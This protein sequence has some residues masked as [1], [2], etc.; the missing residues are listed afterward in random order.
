M[1]VDHDGALDRNAL[2]LGVDQEQRQAVA[3]ADGACGARG[4]DEEIGDVAVD[5]ERLG[6]REL[7]TVAGAHGLQVGLQRAMLCA[8]VDRK[9]REQRAVGNFWQVLGFLRG[10]AATVQRRGRDHAGGEERRRHQ[11]AAD[12]LHHDAGLHETKPAAAE[13][14]RH[15]EAG[16]THFGEG[17]PKLLGEAGGVFAIAQR[18]Q[19]R[20][21][22]LVADQAA[23]TV[24]Q[25]G[26][27]FGEDEGHGQVPLLA[28]ILNEQLNSSFRDGPKGQARN[29]YSRWWLWIPGSRFARPGMTGG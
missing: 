24:A 26:L 12:L 28:I 3:L 14:F 16:K 8:L 29:P 10:I 23:R 6:T 7:E 1:R 15:Q 5:D 27:F 20:H 13:L 11:G 19:V 22:R 21:R 9:R 4:D 2:G 18:S 17:V 25:H